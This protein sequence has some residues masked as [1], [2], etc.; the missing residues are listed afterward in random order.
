MGAGSG[1][2]DIYIEPGSII[3]KAYL[4]GIYFGNDIG[5][6]PPTNIQINSNTYSFD[7]SNFTGIDFEAFGNPLEKYLS[8]H[9]IDVTSV[10]NPSVLN[11]SITIP[12]Q[13]YQCSP[14]KF[15]CVFLYVVYENPIFTSP[16]TSYVL[17]N[18]INESYEVNY[19]VTNLNPS[20]PNAP[21]GFATYL[22]RLGGF[23]ASDG[24]NLYFNDGSW[25]NVGLLK[26]ADNVNSSWDGAGVKGHFY[27]QDEIQ[28]FQKDGVL[29]ELSLA[30]S[31][32]QARKIYVQDRLR[33]RGAEVHA[34]LEGG[35]HV[36]VCGDAT[37]MAKDVH[38][39]LLALISEHGNRSAEEAADYLNALQAQGR[40][41]R[42]V[43]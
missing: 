16:T 12:V 5:L 3:K 33:E 22:D 8:I 23:I 15:D 37:R 20:T 10:I 38:A 28:Q 4:F 31:R 7:D 27:Y 24:S 1:S 34:W 43:Y 18:D 9:T 2:F 32:D 41:A 14:C 40:Y 25:Q 29:N 21:I 6:K 35:A 39:A 30:F 36:Y 26:G 11:Y 13:N 19:S 42:D 17:L